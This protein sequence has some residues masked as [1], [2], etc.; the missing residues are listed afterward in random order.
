MPLKSLGVIEMPGG[1]GSEFDHAAFDPKTRRVFVAHTARDC[2]EV[3]DRDA[4]KHIATLRYSATSSRVTRASAP[5]GQ[6]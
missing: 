6:A 3:I 5:L 2:V 4:Q 1:K